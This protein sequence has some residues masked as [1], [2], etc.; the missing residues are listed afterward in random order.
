MPNDSVSGFL[1]HWGPVLSCSLVSPVTDTCG[2]LMSTARELRFC[3][4]VTHWRWPKPY[5]YSKHLSVADQ[6]L[7]LPSCLIPRNFPTYFKLSFILFPSLPSTTRW[8]QTQPFVPLFHSASLPPGFL[9]RPHYSACLPTTH[10]QIKTYKIRAS[11]YTTMEWPFVRRGRKTM[12]WC[13]W[14]Q[15]RAGWWVRCQCGL[16]SRMLSKTKK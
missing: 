2:S 7:P 11:M 8:L 16:P 5:L 3:M 12:W 14:P 1:H 9:H 10:H 6:P 15:H 13:L 4:E